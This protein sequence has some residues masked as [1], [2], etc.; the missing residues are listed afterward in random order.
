M[1]QF[2]FSEKEMQQVEDQPIFLRGTKSVGVVIFHG[3]SSFPRQVKYMA[4]FL[5][6]QGYWVSVPMLK[7][8]GT[9]PEDLEQATAQDWLADAQKAVMEM[10]SHSEI[11]KIIVGG[12]SM[13]GNLALLVSQTS[14]VDGIFT[15]GTPVHFKNHF[16]IW[17]STTIP[18]WAKRYQ[19]KK[20]PKSIQRQKELLGFTS[21]RYF[22]LKSVK[23][24]LIIVRESVFSLRKVTAPLL[25]FQTKTDYLIARYSPWIMYNAVSSKYRKLQWL[26]SEAGN[27]ILIQP[28]TPDFFPVLGDFVKAIETGEIK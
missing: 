10:K 8:H 28:D 3:W 20:Y 17:L 5:H 19:K 6:A 12:T 18:S 13:G 2:G 21:Y 25:I 22:P 1:P 23:E 14:A 9:V 15:I 4:D 26:Q 24:C 7:G 27:H 16:L 11:K